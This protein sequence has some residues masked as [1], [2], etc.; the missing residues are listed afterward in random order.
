[1]DLVDL[2]IPFRCEE[3]RLHLVYHLRSDLLQ[4]FAEEAEI[5]A[6]SRPQQPWSRTPQP[7]G[8][9]AYGG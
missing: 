4:L 3:D 5:T 7:G 8:T 1:M 2:L 6:A 9:T